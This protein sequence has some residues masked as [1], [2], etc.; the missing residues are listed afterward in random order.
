MGR[1]KITIGIIGKTNVGKSTFFNAATLLNAEIQPY[2]FTTKQPNI[3]I[4]HVSAPCVC[5]E[6]KVVDNPRNSVCI[7]GWRFHPITLIDLPGLIKG[8]HAGRGLGNQFLSVASQSDALIHMVDA[9]GSID[10]DGNIVE[11]GFGDPLSDYYEIEEELVLWYH[12]LIEGNRQSIERYERRYGTVDALHIILSGCKVTKDHIERALMVT[13]LTD[14]PFRDWDMEESKQFAY[15]I[16]EISKPTVVVANKI[17]LE[18]AEE[19]YIRLSKQL[20]DVVV[21]PASAD[22]ELALRRA[23]Q[24]GL[25]EYIPGDEEFRV[26]NPSALTEKQKKALEYMERFVFSKIMRTGVQFA[27]NTLVFKVMMYKYVYPVEDPNKLTDKRG[28]VLP[29]VF[30]LP[31]DA[32]LVDLAKEIHSEIAKKLLYGIDVRTGLKLP[33]DYILHDRDVVHLVTA[34]KKGV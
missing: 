6:F 27:L 28:R 3:G 30:L 25:V 26:K 22:A 7:K 15:A 8:A 1:P 18:G 23:Q 12:K 10:A 24:K 16:R 29:D 11:P 32:T 5:K 17:D 19:N 9:S 34:A 20:K 4:A 14:K 31:R 21:I 33:K 13:G 2:P